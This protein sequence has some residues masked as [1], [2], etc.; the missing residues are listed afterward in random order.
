MNDGR[1]I[2]HFTHVKN[3]NSIFAN[4]GFDCDSRMDRNGANNIANTGIKERR[5]WLPVGVHPYGFVADYVPFYFAPRSPMLYVISKGYVEG[6]DS[7]QRNIVYFVSR[8]DIAMSR[9][10]CCIS[11]RN[12]AKRTA[13]FYDA[14]EI[15]DNIDWDLM[16]SYSWSNTPDDTQRKERR[17]AEFLIHNFAPIDIFLGVCTFDSNIQSA[18]SNIVKKHGLSLRCAV[19]REWYY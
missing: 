11:D 14:V 19:K 3:L 18:V 13:C 10:A 1:L 5:R 12:A 17:M 2:Y 4:K 15:D 7:D 8:T 9:C 16:K 6:V